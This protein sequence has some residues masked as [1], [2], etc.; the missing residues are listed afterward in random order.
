M[1]LFLGM[2]QQAYSKYENGTNV[3]GYKVLQHIC[4]TLSVSADWLFGLSD[5]TPTFVTG[6][7]P[8]PC[9]PCRNKDVTISRLVETNASQQDTIKSHERTIASQQKA[10]ARLVDESNKKVP[11]LGT[12][13]GFSG[14]QVKKSS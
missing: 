11:S 5:E 14:G 4:V 12:S 2:A 3:P 8:V 13:S 1:A 10:I 9:L 7:S 6:A